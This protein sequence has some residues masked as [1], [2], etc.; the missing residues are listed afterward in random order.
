MSAVQRNIYPLLTKDLLKKFVFLA[1]PRQ[2]GKTTLAKIMM[3][4]KKGAYLLYDDDEDRRQILDKHYLSN[5]WVCLDEFHKFPR[6]KNHIKGVYDKHHEHLHLLLTGS[7]RLDVYQ[8]S[9]DSLLGRYY[10]HHLH[11][12]T[13][14]ELNSSAF[15]RLIENPLTP[16]K[17]LSHLK[18][19][20][21]FGGF[22]EPFQTQSE[23]EHRRWSNSRR[24]L[25]IR[26]DLR[27]M[28]H[29][30]LLG[31]VEQLMLLLPHRI[32]ALFSFNALSE[33]IHVSPLTIK[34][35]MDIFQRLFIVF[36]MTPYSK[37]IIRSLH[38]QPKFFFTDWSQVID[39]GSRFENLVAGHLWKAVQ[40]WTDLGMANLAL[41]YIRDR[42]RRE[43][44][45]L[46]TRD[47][48]PWFLVEA[49]VSETRPS[50]NL[51]YFSRRL[52]IP[53]IQIILKENVCNRLGTILIVSAN[54]WL[55]H[56][57]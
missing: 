29:I 12:L 24:N 37:R 35:W 33:D 13:L 48:N 16:H 42:D 40:T 5:N 22:P 54:Q 10:M 50:D 3:R 57:P 51:E 56:L 20:L 43:V 39:D 19:L 9:G 1:G 26:E 27:E 25:L 23:Q 15:P 18:E 47:Q 55:G 2:V 32:G 17:P 31:L 45:F 21:R 38:K 8:K 34:N 52:M 11:P 30:G 46:V 14:G 53:G 36:Q 7:A 28:S 41:H 4:E 6:W 44:D 49:K